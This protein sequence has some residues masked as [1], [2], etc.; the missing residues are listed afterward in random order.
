MANGTQN[1]AFVLYDASSGGTCLWSSA[2]TDAN[3]ATVDCGSPGQISVTVTDGV[4]SVLLGDTTGNTQNVVPAIADS[5]SGLYLGVRIGSDSEMTPRKRIVSSFLATES[6]DADLLDGFDTAQAGG[7]SAFVPVTTANGNLV[8][9]GA[10]QGTGVTQGVLTINPASAS[11]GQIVFAVDVGGIGE[12]TVDAGGNTVN[13]GTL[14]V[15][16][17]SLTTSSTTFNLLN[18]TATTINL[19]GAATTLSVG[20][21]TGTTAVNNALTVTGVLTANGGVNFNDSS[22]DTILIGQNGGTA[23]TVTIAGDVSLTDTQWSV[24]SAG[25]ASFAGLSSSGTITFSGVST[26]GAMIISGG[27]V[28]SEAQLAVARGGTGA[29]TFTSNGVLYGNGTSSVGVTA[30][31]GAGTLCLVST[32]GGAPV[33]S[34]CAGGGASTVW[35][36]LTAPA[37]T[38][39]LN[40]AEFA[41]TFTWD[42]G[43]TAATLDGFTI[44]LTN[45]ATTDVNTQR[46]VVIQNNDAAGST[47]TERLLV[48]NNA[49][50]TEAVTTA[51]EITSSA[52]TIGTAIDVSGSNITT[53]ISAGANNISAT[54][55]SITGA[56]GL[57][58]TAGNIA[59]NGGSL[60]TT[61]T[62]ANV[63]NANATTVNF[64]GAATTLGV[65]ASTGTT[66]VNNALTVTGTETANG[67]FTANGAVNLNDSSA[68]TILIGQNGGTADTVTIA[69]DISLTDTQWSVTAAGAGAFVSL[70]TTAGNGLDAASAGILAIGNTTATSVSLCNSAACDIILIGT[71]TDADTIT[72]GDSTDTTVSITDD[73]W[74]ITA[75]GVANFVSVGA[76]TAG[77]G[78]FTTLSSTGATTIGNDSATVAIDSSDW[79]ITTTGVTNGL[80][81][82][83]GDDNQST[84]NTN[85]NVTGTDAISHTLNF[86]IDG[87][88]GLSIAATGDGAG[89]VGVRTIQVGVSAAADVVTIGDANADISLTDAQWSISAA[90]VANFVSVGATTAGT[91]AFTTLTA[92]PASNVAALTVTGTNLTSANLLALDSRNTTGTIANIAVGAATVQG[93]GA[94]IGMAIDLGTNMTGANAQ[95]MTNISLTTL[96]STRSGSGT[97]TLAGFSVASSAAITQN[98]ATGTF[99]WRGADITAPVATVNFA[100]STVAENGAL[101]TQSAI[102][103]TAGTISSNGVQILMPASGAI[104]TGG[105][106]NGILVTAPTTSGPAAGTLTGINIANLTSAGAGTENALTIGTG[107]DTQINASGFSVGTGGATTITPTTNTAAL[108]VTGTNLTTANSLALVARNTSG[109]IANISY[110]GATTV[111]GTVNGLGV[112]LSTNVTMA[113]QDMRGVSITLPAVTN[114]AASAKT[115][116][117]VRITGGALIQNTLGGLSVENAIDIYNPDVTQTTGT[118]TTS[119]VSVVTG[120]ITTGGRQRGITVSAVGVG[121]GELIGVNIGDIT[122]GAGIETALSLGTGWDTAISASGFSVGGGGATTITPTTNTA[123]L[124]VTGT[125]LTSAN[126]LA[127]G[128][129]NTTGTIANISVGAATVQGSGALIGMAIDLGTNMTGAN[130]QNMTN[131]SLTTLGSTRSGSGTETLAGFS[132]ASSA[133]ITQNTATGTFNWRGSD[134]TAPAATVNFAG[135]T[136]TENGELITLSAITGT[137]GTISSNGVQVV[138]PASGSIVTAGTMNGILVTAPTTSGPAA[139]TLT[140]INIANLTSAGAGTENA[141]TI[142]T[143]WDTQINAT[144]FSVGTGG[145]TNITPSTNTM[146]F[147]ITGTNITSAGLVFLDSRMTTGTIMNVFASSAVTQTAGTLSGEIIDLDTNMTGANGAN[148]VNLQ[149]SMDATARTGSG[150]ESLTGL[151]ISSGGALSQTTAAGNIAWTGASITSPA[152]TDNFVASSVTENALNISMGAIT[153]TAGTISSQGINVIFPVSGAIVTA[154]TMIGINVVAPTTSGPAAGTLTGISISGLISAGAGTENALTIGTG[155]DTQINATG[156]SVGTGGATTITPSTNVAALTVTGTN[157]TSANLLALDSRNTSG[158][159]ENISVGAATVQGAAALTGLAIDLDTN[160]TGST[161]NNITG[162]DVVMNAL[163]QTAANTTTYRGYNL[164]AAGA[165]VQNTAAGTILWRGSEITMPNITQTTGSIIATG[166]R[167]TNGS[168]TTSGTQAGL[169]MNAAGV[170][171]GTLYGIFVG[172]ITGGAGAEVAFTAGDGWD[173]GISI[174]DDITEIAFTSTTP[175]ISIAGGGTLSITDGTNTLATIIDQGTRGQITTGMLCADAGTGC[176]AFAAGRL[177][178]DTAGTS[179]ADD[180]GDTFDLAEFFPASEAVGPGDVLSVDPTTL[181]RVHKSQ[182]PYEHEIM[183]VA[184]SRPALAIEEGWFSAGG[185]TQTDPLKP[186]VALVGRVPVKVTNEN[187]PIAPGDALTASSTPGYAMRATQS[188]YVVGT[189][190]QS[191]NGE[192]GSVR[193]FVNPGWF[194]G[195]GVTTLQ[196]SASDANILPVNLSDLGRDLAFHG[197][198]LT[199][200]G[201]LMSEN[202]LWSIDENGTITAVAIKTKNLTTLSL[203]A[204]LT[205]ESQMIGQAI[206]LRGTQVFRVTNDLVT[207]ESK[208]FIT[209]RSR[210]ETSWWISGTDA[211][212]FEISLGAPSQESDLVFDYWIVG[213]K[214]TRPPVVAPPNDVSTPIVAPPP[215]PEDMTQQVVTSNV[216]E[217][218]TSTPAQLDVE[219]TPTESAETSSTP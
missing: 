156:F 201:R 200:I 210:V 139:G 23:D 63:V 144:G 176:P 91:G 81:S 170:G 173:T 207:A 138:I 55:W 145:A 103:G 13:T 167:L 58:T 50:T 34:S 111:T 12:F 214:D 4:F 92:T 154:G 39:S 57:F 31:G 27:V 6:A 18:T 40:H 166:F 150:T 107:W 163:T 68:D 118:I 76:T 205:N 60:T 98:T 49:D 1:V 131:I 86:Q 171:A 195:S 199:G 93:S 117:G 193:V 215:A 219:P 191:F 142:G 185:V 74:S 113:D 211:G 114:V 147:Q 47:A 202:G 212:W 69:G 136:V 102:T 174:G 9:T 140:G 52:G 90:G 175:T 197:S 180:P 177:Y 97:E 94:L 217:I 152:A 100:G 36:S 109:T 73:N 54:N 206:I 89:A 186:L 141:L 17:G 183:G 70:T 182:N 51:L 38:L 66:T 30:A 125:N 84:L 116:S 104:V 151:L 37:T 15:N 42:T 165:L 179:G 78:A 46:V 26:A 106:M 149:L 64:A 218:S 77:T 33:F 19:G 172:G 189:A 16:G 79:N 153:G 164:S 134:I 216:T 22:A 146:A 83:A 11:A 181:L 43:S 190:L 105:T 162:T 158:T 80:A 101:I 72:I 115:I 8:L 129:R 25:V 56:S 122:N 59:M 194:N 88:T 14:A 203:T 87:N 159:I 71:N 32:N 3:T 85:L 123:A 148:M 128:S 95:N 120:A 44:T 155:W 28:T 29:A 41:T 53:A 168:I 188:G 178:V 48:L 204:E 213:V 121:A 2:N 110:G 130:A 160:L 67:I 35:S 192:R 124:T 82:I 108:T 45:D 62:T 20:A 132:V 187:G 198:A 169:Y 157:L 161:G 119:G 7:T 112:D 99:N 143:G 126:L 135:S 65:G 137:A 21:S 10:P 96:G 61:A 127:L 196:T 75:A 184:S 24:S 5:V 209:F 133:A 208:I